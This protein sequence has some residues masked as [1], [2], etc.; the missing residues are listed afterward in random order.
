[1]HTYIHTYIHTYNIDAR[2]LWALSV[3]GYVRRAVAPVMSAC[4]RA[5]HVVVIIIA[6]NIIIIII[7]IIMITT[8]AYSM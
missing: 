8:T 2:T 5:V 1:M 3:P 4:S 6:M 7:I